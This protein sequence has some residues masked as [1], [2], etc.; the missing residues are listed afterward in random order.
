M[1]TQD[2]T[3]LP[4]KTAR[5]PLYDSV[6]LALFEL[7]R[8]ELARLNSGTTLTDDDSLSHRP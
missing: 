4:Q 8:H 7:L 6:W 2:Q 3:D 5:R 1:R